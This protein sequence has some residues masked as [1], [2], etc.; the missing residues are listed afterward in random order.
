M[1]PDILHR[2]LIRL[3]RKIRIKPVSWVVIFFWG[4][5][6]F[7]PVNSVLTPGIINNSNQI[8]AQEPTFSFDYDFSV[9][10]ILIE[11]KVVFPTD[12]SAQSIL[13][14]ERHTGQIVYEKNSQKQQIP[15]SLTKIMTALVV[16]ESCDLSK[17]VA[18]SNVQSIGSVMDIKNG[19][20]V[21]Y[22]D[23]LMGMLIVSGNDAAEL[24]TRDCFGSEQNAVQKMNI[25]AQLL[26]FK[27]TH[28]SDVTGIAESNHYSSAFDL[29]TIAE[30]VLRNE[31]LAAIV[32]TKENSLVSLDQNR[33]Y[34]LE[35]SNKM[36][37][38]DTAIYGVKTGY[39]E[40]AGEC[41]IFA[42]KQGE[43]DFIVTLLGSEDRFSDGRKILGW[44]KENF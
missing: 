31:K 30:L 44:L 35:N 9:S 14:R 12:I 2:D 32:Q 5:L 29:T 17:E 27:N 7:L 41:L 26:G 36:L 3:W 10:N 34:N 4:L 21:T 8:F 18:V 1:K 43:N 11:R 22:K 37:W 19:E 38:D 33:W 15:A 6:F 39:T 25:K 28:F 16:L 24:L 42:Y 23:L 20:R 40:K 13:I